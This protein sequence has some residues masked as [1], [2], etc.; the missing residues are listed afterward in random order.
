MVSVIAP[1]PAGTLDGEMLVAVGTGLTGLLTVNDTATDGFP[2]EFATVTRGVP[3]TAIAL[4]GIFT[5]NSVTLKNV[6]DN[7]LPPKV[8]MEFAVKLLPVRVS[9]KDGP[10]AV[11]LAGMSVPT[12][13]WRF[14]ARMVRVTG[15]VVSAPPAPLAGFV[16]VTVA[17]PGFAMS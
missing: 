6:G 9:V 14:A 1:F 3:A 7:W 4:E 15:L 13:G 16:T 5:C 12:T 11:A 17:M 2:S 10:P 8:T